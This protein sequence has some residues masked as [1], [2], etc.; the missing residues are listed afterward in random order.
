MP[1]ACP[2]TIRFS[3]QTRY[4]RREA[5]YH[6]AGIV[7]LEPGSWPLPFPEPMMKRLRPIMISIW[8][9][10]WGRADA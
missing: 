2:L 9:R 1:S 3:G 8:Q 4:E 6:L 10:V 5:V 7:V